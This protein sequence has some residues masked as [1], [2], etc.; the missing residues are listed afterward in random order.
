MRRVLVVLAFAA[1][2]ALP[3]VAQ[4]A[5]PRATCRALG[6]D[7][8]LRPIPQSLIGAARAS[9]ELDNMPPEQIARGT[10]WRCRAGAVLM[11]N[12]GA[13]LP[14]GKANTS[15]TL[16]PEGA[17]WCQKNPNADFVPA[18]ISG[19]DSVWHWRCQDGTPL[20]SGPPA[21][22]TRAGFW[23]GTWRPLQ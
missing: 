13:N 16:P 10:V 12:Y 5:G 6:T 3:S 9:F 7:D 11:C 14:C 2:M 4:A 17:A 21:R 20:A 22:P 23:C 1:F 15:R 8:T 19:H 18:Y